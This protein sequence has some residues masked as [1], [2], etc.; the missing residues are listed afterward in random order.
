MKFITKRLWTICLIAVAV[1]VFASCGDDGTGT[2]EDSKDKFLGDYIGE[3]KCAG[4]LA[5]VVNEPAL[6]FSITNTSPEESDKV[7]LNMPDLT[8]PLELVG[9]VSGNNLTME[10]TTVEDFMVTS[11]TPLTLDVTA[12][13]NGSLAGDDLTA[14]ID[15]EGKTPAGASLGTDKCTVIAV[16]Q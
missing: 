9:T 13:G 4:L 7:Q 2:T 10:E 8:L 15:L 16:K 14:T 6:A 11:P 12:S 3:V 5:T 1:I